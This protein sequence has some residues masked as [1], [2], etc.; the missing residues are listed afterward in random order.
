MKFDIIYKDIK[1]NKGISM[2][3]FILF[4]IFSGMFSLRQWTKN[5]KLNKSMK[6]LSSMQNQSEAY[7]NKLDGY[8]KT[9]VDLRMEGESRME[10]QEGNP[11]QFHGTG[12]GFLDYILEKQGEK[13][14]E[15]GIEYYVEAQQLPHFPCSE[16]DTI[17]IFDN[18]LENTR[19]SCEQYRKYYHKKKRAYI[20]IYAE[21]RPET[22][23]IRIGNTKRPD[24]RP[25]Q[26]RFETTKKNQSRHGVGVQ[27]IRKIVE[28][29]Q[30]R[31]FF[32][33]NRTLF[34]CEIYFPIQRKNGC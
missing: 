19:E 34:V 23:Y 12:C 11:E 9:L 29:Y 1:K 8:H 16:Y 27:L 2:K 32:S 10:E 7:Y 30:G 13:A 18:L 26:G 5:M 33:D 15:S 25:L 22:I 20:H 31:I 6:N 4:I 14:I 28:L 21:E 24:Q 3:L 17:T